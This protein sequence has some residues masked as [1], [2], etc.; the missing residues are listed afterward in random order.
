MAHIDTG[1]PAELSLPL[2]MK[3]DFEFIE[4]PKV[5]GKARIPGNHADIWQGRL[6]A[7]LVIGTIRIENPMVNFI[8]PVKWVNI[9]SKILKDYRVNI[10]QKNQL[11]TFE[12]HS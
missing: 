4:E 12:A 11:I 2:H 10:D 6:K 5:V 3:D 9:G 7:D 8:A 1:S